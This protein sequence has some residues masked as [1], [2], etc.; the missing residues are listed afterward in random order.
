MSGK[1]KMFVKLKA[2]LGSAAGGFSVW[3]PADPSQVTP[4]DG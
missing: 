1:L 2:D 3:G 4:T